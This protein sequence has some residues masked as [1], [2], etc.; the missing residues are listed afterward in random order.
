MPITSDIKSWQLL[1]IKC[2][3][4]KFEIAT[5]EHVVEMELEINRI[6]YQTEISCPGKNCEHGSFG[7]GPTPEEGMMNAWWGYQR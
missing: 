6:E 2:P 3:K 4:C 7:K 1:T 5:V